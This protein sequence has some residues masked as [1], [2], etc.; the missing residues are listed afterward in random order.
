[1][2][3]EWVVLATAISALLGF[4]QAGGPGMG[5]D[6]RPVKVFSNLSYGSGAVGRPRPGE[7][8]L[9]LDVYVPVEGDADVRLPAILLLHGG[10]FRRGSKEGTM[11]ELARALASRGV[12]AVSINYRLVHDSPPGGAKDELRRTLYAAREDA[13]KAL[14][15]MRRNAARY[16]ID[17][18]RIGV[19]GSSAGAITGLFLAYGKPGSSPVAAVVDLWGGLYGEERLIQAGDPPLLIVHGSEDRT[20]PYQLALDLEARCQEAGV[21]V[22]F[23]AVRGAE[24]G[25]AAIPPDSQVDGRDLA[26]LVADFLKE[27]PA[28]KP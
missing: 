10:G 19:G 21:P 2:K 11:G 23:H 24:H 28:R 1:M 16:R 5:H 8:E 3:I 6:Q 26:T 14:S 20:V 22:E 15:W 25:F 17:G 7:K 13:A 27:K 4:L 9:L 12:V 18:D